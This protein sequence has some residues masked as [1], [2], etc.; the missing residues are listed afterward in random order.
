MAKTKEIIN[1]LAAYLSI[2]K[3]NDYATNGL[4]I[5]G[6]QEINKIITGVTATPE[7]I[8]KAIQEKACA[9]LVHHGYFW[10]GEDPCLRGAKKTKIKKLLENDLNLLAYHLPLDAHP[11]LGNNVL[12]AKALGIKMTGPL[13]MNS[14]QTSIGLVGELP[15]EGQSLEDFCFTIEKNLK[16]KPNII[17]A[18]DKKIKTIAW[19]T[20]AAQNFIDKAV[21]HGTDAYLTGE[22]S[23]AS[24]LKAK[25]EGVHFLA[26]GHHATETFGVRALGEHLAEHFSIETKFFDT[27]ENI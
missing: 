15:G 22:I 27:K 19:C 5:E 4:Q 12:L 17:K 6:K 23:L 2:A 20:G 26:C 14:P 9:V 24:A 16:Q 21:S 1:Y 18:S 7:L 25:E 3:F 10:T 8:D 13:D 11:E